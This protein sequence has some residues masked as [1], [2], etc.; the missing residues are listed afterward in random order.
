MERVE[1]YVASWIEINYMR[2][3]N[4]QYNV[5]AYVASWIEIMQMHYQKWMELC[6]GLRSLVD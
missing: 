5:E 4:T 3:R 2:F 1:A 6:R